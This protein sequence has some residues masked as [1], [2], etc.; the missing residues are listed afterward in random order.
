M[1]AK[2][3]RLRKLG[4]A[5]ARGVTLVEVLIVLAIMALIAGGATAL[6][7]P[8]FKKAQIKTA[9]LSAAEIK[10]STQTYIELDLAGNTDKCPTVNDLVEAKKLEKGKTDDPW[11]Q[12]FKI[13]CDGGDITV[14]SNGRD[15]KE[16]T[17]DDV[18]DDFKPADVERVAKL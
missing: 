13:H 8:E 4:R 12:P 16:G 7:F 17:P 6:L 18:K 1:V 5:A 14:T 2:A 3:N 9:V 15:R 10:K 11:G